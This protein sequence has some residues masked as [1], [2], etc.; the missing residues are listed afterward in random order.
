[1][2]NKYYPKQVNNL[3]TWKKDQ[4]GSLS[5]SLAKFRLIQANET[6]LLY[7]TADK[8]VKLITTCK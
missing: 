4:K 8:F 7:F 3:V 5:K 2:K 1:M 6:E